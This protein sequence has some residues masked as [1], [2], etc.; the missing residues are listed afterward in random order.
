MVCSLVLKIETMT[1]GVVETVPL[2]T[3]EHGGT[4]LAITPISTVSTS[5]DRMT[6]EELIGGILL[7]D[8]SL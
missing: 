7:E 8:T 5:M 3:V 2:F 6:I 1:S 4:I